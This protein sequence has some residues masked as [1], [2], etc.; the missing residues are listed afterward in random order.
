MYIR[1]SNRRRLLRVSCLLAA[2]VLLMPKM[3][4]PTAPQFSAFFDAVGLA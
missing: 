3:E 4:L 2:V 1:R